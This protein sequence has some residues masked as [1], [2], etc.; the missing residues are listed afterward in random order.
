MHCY[1][2]GRRFFSPL[3]ILFVCRRSDPALPWRLGTAVTKKVGSAVW[4]NRLRRLIRESFR[5]ARRDVTNGYDYVVVPKRH[6]NPRSATL[7]G[8]SAELTPLL[9]FV[10]E[11]R[12]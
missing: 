3:F 6:V 5:L 11:K 2:T 4:R 12:P 9:R 1:D 7:A 10:A 8:V